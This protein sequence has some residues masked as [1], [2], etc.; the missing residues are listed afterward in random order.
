MKSADCTRAMKPTSVALFTESVHLVLF[1][2]DKMKQIKAEVS[3]TKSQPIE[4]LGWVISLQEQII[5]GSDSQLKAIK[6][7]VETSVESILVEHFK[8]SCR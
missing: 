1:L 2:A 6:T 3:S 8:C 7:V 4:N 5:D